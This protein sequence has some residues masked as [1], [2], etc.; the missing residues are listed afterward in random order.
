MKCIRHKGQMRVHDQGFSAYNQG[1]EEELKEQCSGVGDWIEMLILCRLMTGLTFWECCNE[2]NSE[3]STD[4]L[5]AEAAP[6]GISRQFYWTWD[7]DAR[8]SFCQKIFNQMSVW[9]CPLDKCV[10]SAASTS[11][12]LTWLCNCEKKSKS[13]AKQKN[14]VVILYNLKISLWNLKAP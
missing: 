9:L 3:A 14:M 4:F 8:R 6:A 5:L 13:R 12:S 7:L 2:R 1:L 11:Q 10:C